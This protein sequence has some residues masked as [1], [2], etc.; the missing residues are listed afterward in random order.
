MNP[1]DPFRFDT[2]AKT[3]PRDAPGGGPDAFARMIAFARRASGYD[4]GGQDE[5]TDELAARRTR[6][7]AVRTVLFATL[8]LALLN[9]E[10]LRSWATTLPP[11]WGSQT[12]RAL[13]DVWSTRTAAAG[14]DAPRK[15]LHDAYRGLKSQAAERR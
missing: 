11:T 6:R 5:P 12:I 3:E 13:A 15:T 7:W 2:V 10:S 8:T 4:P 1:V 14:L 9:A